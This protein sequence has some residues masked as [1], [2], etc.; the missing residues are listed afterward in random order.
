MKRC[1]TWLVNMT[2]AAILSLGVCG[3]LKSTAWAQPAFIGGGLD[4]NGWSPVSKNIRS[5]VCTDPHGGS[6]KRFYD[7][8]WY[9]GHDEPDVQFYSNK[10][11]SGNDMVYRISLPQRDPVP[12]QSG[13]SVAW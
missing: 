7:N 6:G 3:S 9:I 2:C 1:T 12:T 10:P 8:G 13:S 11:G 4:C 5:M